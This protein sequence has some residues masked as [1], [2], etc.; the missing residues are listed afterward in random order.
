[1]LFVAGEAVLGIA[2]TI[3]LG[4]V[5]A[6]TSVRKTCRG[7][8]GQHNSLLTTTTSMATK[9]TSTPR[10]NVGTV[11]HAATVPFCVASEARVHLDAKEEHGLNAK[12]L[13]Q[14]RTSNPSPNQ[15]DMRY[16]A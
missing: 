15:N 13:L 10:A 7:Q 5:A 12:R 2:A 3:S 6:S 14:P 16:H 4:C 11:S 1:M 9:A 8:R